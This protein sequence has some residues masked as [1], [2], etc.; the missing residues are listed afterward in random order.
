ME[1]GSTTSLG[2]ASNLDGKES[3]ELKVLGAV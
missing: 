2:F 3:N 1:L